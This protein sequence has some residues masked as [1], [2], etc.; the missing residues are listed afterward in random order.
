MRLL[1]AE[2]IADIIEES[3]FEPTLD[4]LSAVFASHLTPV[5]NLRASLTLLNVYPDIA[6]ASY[7]ADCNIV[8]YLGSFIFPDFMRF[9]T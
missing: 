2:A 7:V 6:H 9:I 1:L 5:R 4:N 3:E 8:A